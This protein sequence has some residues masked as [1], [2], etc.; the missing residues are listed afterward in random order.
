V[1]EGTY[2]SIIKV[3]E[4]AMKITRQGDNSKHRIK[5][6]RFI[7]TRLHGVTFQKIVPFVVI[8]FRTSNSTKFTLDI[9]LSVKEDERG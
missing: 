7:I 8:L 4:Y 9:Q 2:A 6:C 3:E 5:K 1:S